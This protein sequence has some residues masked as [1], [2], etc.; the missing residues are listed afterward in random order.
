MVVVVVVVVMLRW[1]WGGGWWREP[2]ELR[3][4]HTPRSTAGSDRHA[5]EV[6]CGER[7]SC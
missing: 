2:T 1:C 6:R 3:F 5:Y 4:L 7:R